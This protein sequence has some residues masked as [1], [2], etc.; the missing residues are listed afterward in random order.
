MLT[1][2]HKL[3]LAL[4]AAILA[5]LS[6]CSVEQ[7]QQ[8]QATNSA[9]AAGEA[10]VPATPVLPVPQPPLNREQLLGAVAQAASDFASGTDDSKRQKQLEGRK[11]ELRMRFG[12][13]GASLES[14]DDSGSFSSSLDEKSGALK[15]SA[16]P[17]LS[18]TDAPVKAVAGDR[19][20][21]VEGFWIGR[22]WML[23]ATCPHVSSA[24]A[25]PGQSPGQIVGIAQ[26]FTANQPRTFRRSGRSYE[27]TRKLDQGDKP[28]GGFDLVVSGRLTALP[29]GRAIACTV[30]PSAGRP[31]C[32]ISAEFGTVSIE[33]ADTHEQLAAWGTG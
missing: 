31:P 8:D 12:C 7:P 30:S 19:F 16:K 24:T 6:G 3:S 2:R 25:A 11:F 18:L 33:R 28:T 29:D 9:N 22:P 15:V 17:T 27:A 14:T 20:E 1:A 23:T 26:F 5:V 4:P 32:I 10:I 13:G 21:S